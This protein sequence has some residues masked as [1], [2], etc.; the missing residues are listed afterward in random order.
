MFTYNPTP[1]Y[2]FPPSEAANL[3]Y[4]ILSTILGGSPESGASAASPPTGQTPGQQANGTYAAQQSSTSVINGT[5]PAP[6]R[7]FSTSTPLAIQP[8]ETA[9]SSSAAATATNGYP[10]QFSQPS[11]QIQP[12]TNG[13]TATQSPYTDFSSQTQ[14]SSSLANYAGQATPAPLNHVSPVA[15]QLAPS[16]AAIAPTRS[17]SD[18]LMD[19]TVSAGT[20]SWVGP[21]SSELGLPDGTSVYKSVTKPYDY[22]EGYH[23]LMKHLPLRC[24]S[25][26]LRHISS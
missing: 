20:A 10:V 24:V 11:P 23:F 22:T 18:S 19:R 7:S 4:S 14:Q 25:R 6:T 13:T 8:S 21:T 16:Q 3:E 17:S 5:W 2:T 1:T 15:V 12:S 26:V 9:L